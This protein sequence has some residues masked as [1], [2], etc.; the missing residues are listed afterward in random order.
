MT[1]TLAPP[2]LRWDGRL[3]GARVPDGRY[4]VRLIERGLS[5]ASSP[6]RIDQTAPRIAQIRAHNRSREPFQGD[7]DRLTTISPPRAEPVP[8]KEAIWSSART[9]R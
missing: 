8:G 5:V 6:L 7:N 4:L 2:P 9:C 1:S 3:N